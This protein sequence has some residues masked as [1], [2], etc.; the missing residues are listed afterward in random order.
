M[1]RGEHVCILITLNNRGNIMAVGYKWVYSDGAPVWP[2]T[3][4][5]WDEVNMKTVVDSVDDRKFDLPKDGEVTIAEYTGRGR[6]DIAAFC[7]APSID[8]AKTWLRSILFDEWIS[9]ATLQPIQSTGR[10]VLWEV[11]YDGEIG[12]EYNEVRASRIMFISK[13]LT[14]HIPSREVREHTFHKGAK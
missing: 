4:N 10:V 2:V 9:G 13:V 7:I 5:H 11:E 3:K 6:S 1:Y 8:I 12:R 14:A